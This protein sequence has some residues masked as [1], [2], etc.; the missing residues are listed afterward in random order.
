MGMKD[1]LDKLEVIGKSE[2]VL[3]QEATVQ[4]LLHGRV[5]WYTGFC[6]DFLFYLKQHHAIFSMWTC[7]RSHPFSQCERVHIWLMGFVAGL[8]FSFMLADKDGKS[9]G[10][11]AA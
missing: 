4:G 3:N 5:V 2:A 6:T 1:D 7:H 10:I 8:G 9:R 11:G